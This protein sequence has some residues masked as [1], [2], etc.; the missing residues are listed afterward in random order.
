MIDGQIS[1]GDI[2]RRGDRAERN[3]P[4]RNQRLPRTKITS[5]FGDDLFA[6]GTLPQL[7]DLHRNRTG[8]VQLVNKTRQPILI[9]SPS[10]YG[11][12]PESDPYQQH[13]YTHDLMLW[14][15]P[16]THK[17]PSALITWRM[18]ER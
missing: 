6:R 3:F 8:G 14:L 7:S 15:T 17:T 5:R 16:R 10:V 9:R 11:K 4:H 1:T 12:A 13:S 2:L 18:I